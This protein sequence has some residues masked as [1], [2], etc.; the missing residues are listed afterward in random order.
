MD[1]GNRRP[2]RESP[3]DP[4]ARESRPSSRLPR[5]SPPGESSL[6]DP[7]RGS[8][9]MR[10]RSGKRA[11][12]SSCGTKE[13]GERPGD[14]RSIR[15]STD[16]CLPTAHPTVPRGKA[17]RRGAP[18]RSR[19]RERQPG[20]AAPPG[21]QSERWRRAPWPAPPRRATEAAGGSVWRA[22]PRAAPQRRV[23]PRRGGVRARA[24]GGPI[25]PRVGS[26]LH[27]LGEGERYDLL[28][29]DVRDEHAGHRALLPEDRGLSSVAIDEER[30]STVLAPF[31]GWWQLLHAPLVHL[32]DEGLLVLAEV[33]EKRAGAA[34]QT[35][36]AAAREPVLH[37]P[38][39]EDAGPERDSVRREEGFHRPRVGGLERQRQPP[40]PVS[41]E[42]GLDRRGY[43]RLARQQDQNHGE[44][45]GEQ[46]GGKRQPGPRTDGGW[47]RRLPIE[48]PV[49]RQRD[50]R[51]DLARSERAA[52]RGADCGDRLPLAP[53]ALARGQVL[54]EGRAAL[55]RQPPVEELLDLVG[56]VAALAHSSFVSFR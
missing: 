9:R 23:R 50:L 55:A 42:V 19:R 21:P 32:A 33:D 20:R 45:R 31:G 4:R 8:A 1:R 34:G 35:V 15:T 16:S 52:S 11:P 37:H 44:G 40:G 29:V 46:S 54:F 41:L 13:R 25:G 14:L 56:E 2:P 7:D 12:L 48:S 5:E 51:R 26:G 53:A 38:E 36:D 6:G 24:R 17:P 22:P 27:G 3:E 47:P 18:P 49:N 30:E 28:G 10:D 39:V 43:G